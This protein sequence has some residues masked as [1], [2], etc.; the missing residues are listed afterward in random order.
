MH[1]AAAALGT[2]AA[3]C[4]VVGDIGADMAAAGAAGAAGVLVPTAVTRA[5]EIAAAP[6]VAADLTAAVALILARER[7]VR[8][9]GRRPWRPVLGGPAG[10]RRRRLRHRAGDPG[11]RRRRAS[12]W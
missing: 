9:A 4:V 11:G 1:A 7:L 8:P 10:L 6:A 3:R 5:E 2:V 12:G